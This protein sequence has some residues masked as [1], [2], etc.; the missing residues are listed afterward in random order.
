[1]HRKIFNTMVV[2]AFL[3][4]DLGCKG[5]MYA[6]MFGFSWFFVGLL[7]VKGGNANGEVGV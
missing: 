4:D 5:V 3:G 7:R 6:F 2:T 1:M